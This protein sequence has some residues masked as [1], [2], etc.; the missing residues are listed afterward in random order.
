MSNSIG[1]TESL[2]APALAVLSAVSLVAVG[3][4]SGVALA[5]GAIILGLG[6]LIGYRLNRIVAGAAQESA[7]RRSRTPTAEDGN[8]DSYVHSVHATAE[9]TMSRWLRHID[10][11]KLQTETAA[12]EL[13]SEFDGILTRLQNILDASHAGDG[14]R[15]NT[16]QVIDAA[17]EELGRMLAGL[18]QALAEKEPMMAEFRQ[19]AQ[20]I[21]ELKRM[22]ADVAKIAKQTNLLALNAAIEAAR[23][24]EAGRGFSV[25]ADEVRKL[26]DLS[27]GIGNEI[28]AKVNAVN[29][30]M[31]SSLAMAA[32]MSEQDQS[33]VG[34]SDATIRG[35]IERFAALAAQ[36]NESSA[37]LVEGSVQ[38]RQQ[39]E[40]VMV[41]LQFQDR[42]T[43]ILDAVGSDIARLRMRL[44]EEESRIA[45]GDPPRPIDVP[46][47]LAAM[48]QTY[49]TIEQHDV[50]HPAASGKVEPTEITF[51]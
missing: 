29:D 28:Q 42:T 39:V 33:L 22:A 27:G 31:R 5:A 12:K 35:V 44:G 34:N 32:R 48:E 6:G 50:A 41:H 47:W 19:L 3:G 9:S 23:A 25:V 8:A 24:G 36:L 21:D 18:H 2:A 37:Q 1:L 10:I 46:A 13:A 43:Q 11:A 40:N 4:A 38:V 20:V 14:A 16:V 17:R 15:G 26:S 49:T 45:A 30:A 7:E 51:F